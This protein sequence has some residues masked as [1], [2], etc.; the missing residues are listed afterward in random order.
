MA[1]EDKEPMQKRNFLLFGKNQRKEQKEETFLKDVKSKML[2]LDNV[3]RYGTHKF[4]IPTN[5]QPLNYFVDKFFKDHGFKSFDFETKI[6]SAKLFS[7]SIGQRV[8]FVDG[9]LFFMLKREEDIL[10]KESLTIYCP[11]WQRTKAK[12]ILQEFFL[13]SRVRGIIIEN[14]RRLNG[15]TKIKKELAT[16]EQFVRP[17][18]YNYLDKLFKRMCT[19]KDWYLSNQKRFKETILLHGTPGTGKTSIFMHFAAKYNLNVAITTPYSFV[20]DFEN[21]RSHAEDDERAPLLVLI[22]DIDA[23]EELVT[24]EFKS[25]FSDNPIDINAEF[26]YSTFINTLDGAQPLNNMIVCLSTN[27]K[28]KLISSVTRRGRVDHDIHI[29]PLTSAEIAARVTTEQREYIATFPD[30]TFSI[31]NITDL[32]YCKTKQEIDEL[33]HWLK[34]ENVI[35]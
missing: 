14:S 6:K 5:R 17:D 20:I 8:A 26:N 30:N 13:A 29:T 27:Y 15:G 23:C 35:D 33:A 16:Q 21:L 11:I 10:S 32:R 22:E 7:Q 12:E 3:V 4:T 24:K 9:V 28:H 25:K 1:F 34:N 2:S 18:V 31:S 19:D